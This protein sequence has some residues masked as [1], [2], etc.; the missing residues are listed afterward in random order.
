MKNFISLLILASPYVILLAVM[1]YKNH[2]KDK[3]ENIKYQ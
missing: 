2:I 3:D 1:L